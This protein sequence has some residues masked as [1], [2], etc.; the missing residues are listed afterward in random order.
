MNITP[1]NVQRR[2]YLRALRSKQKKKFKNW[3]GNESSSSERSYYKKK[4]KSDVVDAPNI[5]SLQKNTEEMLSFIKIMKEKRELKHSVNINMKNVEEITCGSV[6]LLLSVISEFTDDGIVVYGKKPTDENARNVLEQSGFFKFIDGHVDND[7]L[8]TKNNIICQGKY[9]IEAQSTASMIT[10]A[11]E[12]VTG[13]PQRNQK[14]QSLLIEMMANSVNHAYKD[15]KNVKWWIS[16]SHDV[17]LKKVHFVF[18]DN[19][20]GIVKTLGENRLKKVVYKFKNNLDLLASAFS[21][22]IKSRTGLDYRGRG[23]PKIISSSNLGHCSNFVA[24]TNNVFFTGDKSTS[25]VLDEDFS[26]AFYY[27]EL[28][29]DNINV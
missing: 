29:E 19:G 7:N 9:N 24:I 1:L 4:K 3:L 18:V 17:N 26:G 15:K 25:K 12:T 10:Q 13:R 27:F 14:I 23:L 11:M 8:S 20:F 5:F 2:R 21:G 16:A 28:S 6:A 22:A